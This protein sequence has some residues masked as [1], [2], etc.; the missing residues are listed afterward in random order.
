VFGI[1]SLS[2]DKRIVYPIL[3]QKTGGYI[4]YIH[5]LDRFYKKHPRLENVVVVSWMT[6][7]VRLECLRSRPFVVVVHGKEIG[8]RSGFPWDQ[9][10]K[11]V[12]KRADS[13]LAI[14][15]YTKKELF[16]F[17]T[18][19]PQEKIQVVHHG[20]DNHESNRPEE[21]GHTFQIVSIGQWI[22]RKGFDV[23]LRSMEELNGSF[24]IQLNIITDQSC[25]L[26][27]S[28][29]VRVHREV[30]DDMKKRLLAS[31]DVFILANR[32]LGRD[33]EGFGYVVLEAMHAG[34]PC[35]VG[36]RGGPS[37]IIR[38]GIDGFVL[39]FDQHNEL[40]QVLERCIKN[41]H[42]L[43]EMG[44]SAKAHAE[45]YFSESSFESRMLAALR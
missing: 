20:L 8:L 10:Q 12:Y 30:D 21:S 35:I 7:F 24:D 2:V 36:R 1:H 11:W 43:S 5:V 4:T 38:D 40:T 29:H 41:R 44:R 9:L 31:S 22:P 25:P 34:L 33:F 27:D 23:L 3:R 37:E 32:H 45:G 15:E 13:I 42:M 28:K 18:D 39:D 17:A 16:K 6:Y 19:I 14:S 26:S